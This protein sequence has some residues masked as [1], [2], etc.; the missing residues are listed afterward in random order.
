[1]SR[2]RYGANDRGLRARGLKLKL[3]FRWTGTHIMVMSDSSASRISSPSG[4]SLSSRSTWTSR[5][6]SLR[7]Q[8]MTTK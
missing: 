5:I 6:R 1:M 2:N 3:Q 4:V 8:M 7:L